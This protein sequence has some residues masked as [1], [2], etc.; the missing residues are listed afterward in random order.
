MNDVK[1]FAKIVRASNGQQVL[2][3][4]EVIDEKNTL[5]CIAEFDHYQADMKIAGMDDD[6]FVSILDKVGI[7][8]ADKVVEQSAGF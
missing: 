5:H 6:S 4:K 2:F 3:Y 8:M 7:H 1:D